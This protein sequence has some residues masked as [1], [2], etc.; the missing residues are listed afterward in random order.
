MTKA[1]DLANGGF[2]LVLIKPSTVVN[3]PDNGKGTVSFSAA[4]SVSL[5]GV[6]NATYESYRILVNIIGTTTADL[7]MLLR[8]SGTDAATNYNRELLVAD[9]S[10]VSG[11]RVTSQT[12]GFFIGYLNSTYY[13]GSDIIMMS[14]FSSSATFCSANY[15]RT[16]GPQVGLNTGLHTT[17]SSYDGFTISP[18]SGTMTGSVSVYGFNK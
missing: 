4:S 1:R 17:A 12:N 15:V 10:S 5:N 6:F 11:G 8:A 2:G 14:P 9:G 3:G 16:D 13:S 18:A 7:R